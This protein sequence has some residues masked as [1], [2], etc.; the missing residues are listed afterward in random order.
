M[1]RRIPAFALLLAFFSTSGFAM[2]LVPHRAIYDLSLD[3][4]KPGTQVDKARGRIAFQLTGNACEGYAITLRQVT[5]L[6]TGEGQET[7][8]D[9]RSESWESGNSAS[10]RFK[11]QNFVN[12][13]AREDVVG[14]VM[15]QKNDSIAVRV[16]KP[17]AASFVLHGKILMPTEHTRTLLAAAARGEKLVSANIYDGA[18]DGRKIYE[19]LTV[20]GEAILP[21]ENEQPLSAA[22]KGLKRYPVV[23]SYFEMGAA[24][25]LPAY[26]LAFD[27][28]ENGISSALRLNYGNFALKG[29]L[30]SVELLP[31]KPC[32]PPAPAK[33]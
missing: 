15:R 25:R 19:T 14:T 16:T 11:T 7:I 13:E 28:Y 5:A 1:L 21:G 22:L 26:T 29:K 12:R 6:D 10:Y 27:L 23:T 30:R 31:Q 8:S 3:A 32:N 20:I 2:P 9:L 33:R 4:E 17:K 18:P 24:D